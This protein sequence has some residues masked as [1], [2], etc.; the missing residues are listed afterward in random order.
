LKLFSNHKWWWIILIIAT[1]IVSIITSYE[2]TFIGLMVSVA[3]HLL[4]SVIAAFIPWLVYW[5]A[6][7]PLN[8]E[9]MMSTISVAWLVLAVANLLVM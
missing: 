5:L 8:S 3:G 7:R 2:V 4:F 6:G 1:I 9:Q